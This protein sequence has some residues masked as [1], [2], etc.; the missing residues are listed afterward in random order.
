MALMSYCK[1]WRLSV[2]TKKT[3]IWVLGTDENFN[4]TYDGTSYEHVSEYKYLG[5][6]FSNKKKMF[7][8][9]IDHLH[10][11]AMK[12]IFQIKRLDKNFGKLSVKMALMLFDSLVLPIL[13]YGSEIWADSKEV[14][15]KLELL[16]LRYLKQLLGVKKSTSNMGVYGELGRTPLFIKRKLK[17]ISFWLRLKSSNENP[18]LSEMYNYLLSNNGDVPWIC[19]IKKIL[20]ESGKPD[21]FDEVIE[22]TDQIYSEIKEILYKQYWDRWQSQTVDIRVC[23]ILRTYRLFK[24]EIKL[25]PYLLEIKNAVTRRFLSRFRLSSH[26]LYI[27]TGRWQR[28][29]IPPEDR[30]CL[31]CK[32]GVE[33]AIHVFVQ[34][35]R[36]NDLRVPFFIS[37]VCYLMTS[38]IS[39]TIKSSFWLC[40]ALIP[41]S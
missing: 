13:E 7:H 10:T 23:P 35:Q 25:E 37:S 9:H 3:K 41:K 33:D 6:I 2:N 30:I 22:N 31:S 21:I 11:Q 1:K 28:P 20:E 17:M 19:G 29:K 27:E 14:T 15:D 26:N 18:L 36:Y 5:C 8:E 40:Q 32:N 12:A 4:F 24:T 38:R 34:C 16:H 39:V